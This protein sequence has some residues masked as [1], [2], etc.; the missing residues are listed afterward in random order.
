LLALPDMPTPAPRRHSPFAVLRERILIWMW[1]PGWGGDEKE[2]LARETRFQD[3]AGEPYAYLGYQRIG[4]DLA[5]VGIRRPDREWLHRH[6]FDPRSKSHEAMESSIMP[7][8]QHLY[9][10]LSH[11]VVGEEGSF[12]ITLKDGRKIVPTGKANALV[13][14]LLSRDKDQKLPNSLVEK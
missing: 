10:E 4:P 6:L 8:Y 12:V 9:K 1:R 11:G 13:D 3:Y 7:S 2:G 5:N 14:Y